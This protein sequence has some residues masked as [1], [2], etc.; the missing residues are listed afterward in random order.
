MVNRAFFKMSIKDFTSSIQQFKHSPT[1]EQIIRDQL[2]DMMEREYEV[3][4]FYEKLE[5]IFQQQIHPI[6]KPLPRTSKTPIYVACQRRNVKLVDFLLQQ[7][8][9]PNIKGPREQSPISCCVHLIPMLA[10]EEM[11]EKALAIIALLIKNGS[12]FL[13]PEYTKYHNAFQFLQ[14]NGYEKICEDLLSQK[15]HFTQQQKREWELS[16]LYLVV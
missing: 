12:S 3:Q 15:E 10:R 6:N 2:F 4:H 1:Y 16:R 8:A 7:G 13:L 11:K 14:Q 5:Y 9:D